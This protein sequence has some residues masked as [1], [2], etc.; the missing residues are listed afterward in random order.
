MRKFFTG[1]VFTLI[2]VFLQASFPAPSMPEGKKAQSIVLQESCITASCH[3]D[4]AKKKYIHEPASDGE[5]C[6]GCHEMPEEGK[7]SFK[8]VA[9]GAELCYGC[10][11]SKADK[12]YKHAP[13]EEGMCTACHDPHQS[14]NPKQL[15]VPLD[16]GELCYQCHENKADK[17]YKHAP[18]EA[19]MC[20]ACHDP[21]QSDNPKQ[22]IEPPNSKLCFTC[23]ME[24]DFSG[25]TP[26]GPVSEGKCLKCHDPHTSENNAQLLKP[27]PELC[28]GCHDTSLKDTKG[29]RIPSIKAF[30]DN[31][32]LKLHKPFAEGRCTACHSPHPTD[33]YRLLV[34]EYPAEFYTSYSPDKYALCLGCHKNFKKVLS[35]PRTMTDTGFR[36]GNLNLHYRHVN[37]SKGRT[38]R[39]CHHPHGS[40]NPKLIRS[41]FQFGKRRLSI[42]YDKTDT[43]GSCS[44]PCHPTVKYDRYKPYEI[45]FKVTPRKGSD[46]TEEELSLAYQKYLE[47]KKAEKEKSES[48]LEK[49]KQ[50]KEQ[51]D[52]AK[53]SDVKTDKNKEKEGKT[54]SSETNAER[55]EGKK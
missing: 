11:D 7:H 22:L 47:R 31:K 48:L 54:K 20:T 46:A 32:K 14:D 25:S 36:N 43:G 18:V 28:F 8:L 23:H 45:T 49:P 39:A 2:L 40:I 21:H 37:R 27:V 4:F 50:L 34:R 15:V 3:A 16:E 55:K 51:G 6:T 44:P 26:H 13:V 33:T 52:Q 42:E 17:K 30:F 41:S 9:E 29:V 53:T 1:A 10:H 12:K 35:E 38:C 24:E 19:G 5:L